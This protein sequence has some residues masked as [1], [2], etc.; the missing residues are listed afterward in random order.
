LIDATGN[1]VYYVDFNNTGNADKIKKKYKKDYEP[2]SR[3]YKQSIKIYDKFEEKKLKPGDIKNK[4]ENDIEMF[5]RKLKRLNYFLDS[6]KN[7]YNQLYSE[8]YITT[9]KEGNPEIVNNE[10]IKE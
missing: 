9:D 1:Y 3:I 8:N 7:I 6:L 5:E 2:L 10:R 4:C